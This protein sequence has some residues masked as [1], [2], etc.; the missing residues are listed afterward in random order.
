MKSKWYSTWYCCPCARTGV[1]CRLAGWFLRAPQKFDLPA[2]G[3]LLALQSGECGRSPVF[4]I[5]GLIDW[6][7][8]LP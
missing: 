1:H 3:F 5:G 4:C 8:L 2:D 6:I 7:F